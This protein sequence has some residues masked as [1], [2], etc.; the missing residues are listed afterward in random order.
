MQES[1]LVVEDDIDL[2]NDIS[3]ILSE[4]EYKVLQAGNG[5]EAIDISKDSIPDLVVSD[6]M[7][8]NID[9]YGLLDYF[10][11]E[12]ILENVPFIFLS[13]KSTENDLRFGMNKGADDYLTKP[14]RA[15]D[16]VNAV[17][18]R[19]IKKN[20]WQKNF[21]KIR[22][23]FSLAIP[24]ELRTPLIPIMGYTDLIIEEFENLGRDEIFNM[25]KGIKSGAIK[26][27]SRIEKFILFSTIHG[28]LNDPETLIELKNE[29]LEVLG[30]EIIANIY[31]VA[32]GLDRASDLDIQSSFE[33]A[34]LKIPA[35]HL[36]FIINELTENACK[37]SI[38][39]S[40][41]EIKINSELGF[42]IISFKNYGSSIDKE[43]IRRINLFQRFSNTDQTQI[44]SGIGLFLVKEVVDS[45]K[46]KL[47]IVSELQ[48]YTLISAKIPL[49]I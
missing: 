13:A 46:G 32:K 7:M 5:K 21:S 14:F 10:Q 44:E 42:F 39:D 49:N 28:E 29:N 20:K 31:E 43:Q 15:K 35:Y 25:I 30:N 22:E 41:I 11:N 16:L 36:A 45:F 24:H 1:I 23:S 47:E 33:K 27:Y 38:P 18:T 2:R 12:P 40:P 17:Q 3:E 4:A 37:H 6:I 9:G 48:N 8:P 26:L 34:A 19:L